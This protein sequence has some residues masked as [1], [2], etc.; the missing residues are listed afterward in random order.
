M[1]NIQLVPSSPSSSPHISSLLYI[2]ESRHWACSG[3]RLATPPSP[4]RGSRAE[5]QLGGQDLETPSPVWSPG[6]L[7]PHLRNWPKAWCWPH[8][9]RCLWKCQEHLGNIFRLIQQW[10]PAP[11]HRPSI[12]DWHKKEP[13]LSFPYKGHRPPHTPDQA[14]PGQGHI[15]FLCTVSPTA[16]LLPTS[17]PT[18]RRRSMKDSYWTQDECQALSSL[19]MYFLPWLHRWITW[20]ASVHVPCRT[21]QLRE[22]AQL[23]PPFAPQFPHV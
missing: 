15:R 20:P 11:P 8:S 17:K 21:H 3:H 18:G 12:R 2:V 1:E 23:T 5:G 22:C 9:L 14:A 4:A 13:E 6:V 10:A 16:Q 7:A 19:H